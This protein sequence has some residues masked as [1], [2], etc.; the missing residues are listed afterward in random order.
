MYEGYNSPHPQQHLLLFF[1]FFLIIALLVGTKYLRDTSPVVLLLSNLY[2]EIGPPDWFTTGPDSAIHLEMFGL[3]VRSHLH[4]TLFST[5]VLLLS[6][7]NSWALASFSDILTRKDLNRSFTWSYTWLIMVSVGNLQNWE[8]RR[9]HL[10]WKTHGV[11]SFIQFM[12]TPARGLVLECCDK[13][14]VFVFFL[15]RNTVPICRWY[16]CLCRRLQGI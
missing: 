11:F 7:C 4:F 14:P 9:R 8:K 10:M 2:A 5:H 3:M 15:S 6:K 13:T 12:E 16:K 1:G